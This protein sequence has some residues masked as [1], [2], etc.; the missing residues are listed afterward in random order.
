MISR[1][2]APDVV[3]DDIARC[4]VACCQASARRI[5]LYGSRARGDARPD[6]DYDF[7][8]EVDAASREALAAMRTTISQ[9]VSG[10]RVCVDVHVGT[11]ASFATRYSDVGTLEYQIARDGIVVY[12]DGVFQRRAMDLPPLPT[13]RVREPGRSLPKSVG[14]WLARAETDLSAA[15]Q[16]FHVPEP[17]WSI[18]AFHA[19][20]AAEKFLKAAIVAN[21]IPPRRT[22]DLEELQ[23]AC[24]AAVR[25]D[26]DVRAACALLH[27]MWRA[28]RYPAD[29]EISRSAADAATQAATRVRDAVRKIV[30][31]IESP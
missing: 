4:I 16:F 26:G 9:A 21:G 18:I 5:V 15:R 10:C 11:S 20:E 14:E 29:V 31:R 27:G 12:T 2:D 7:W 22:H 6:S 25:D 30:R 1:V 24:P 13:S 3:A 8:I 17:S 28:A 19:H 23:A